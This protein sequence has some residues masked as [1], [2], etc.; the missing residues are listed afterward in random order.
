MGAGAWLASRL[1]AYADSALPPL[2]VKEIRIDAGASASFTALHVSD[3]HLTLVNGDDAGDK[4]KVKL[5]NGRIRTFPNAEHYLAKAIAT[6]H[7]NHDLLLHTGD[8]IDFVSCGNLARAGQTFAADDWYVSS[9]N[10]EF[11]KYVGEAVEDAAY[12]ADS[13]ARVQTVFPN[14]LTFASRV[15]K[16]VNFVAI[17][18]VYYNVTE[19]Q[20][21]L[22]K[23]EVA[24]GLPII[25][26]CHV[27][28]YLPRLCAKQLARNSSANVTG[29]PLEIT[30]RYSA[31]R[32]AQQR[33]DQPTADFIAW[34]KEQ[35]LLKGI[36]CGHLHKYHEERFSPTAMQYVC[37]GGF[38]GQVQRI[39]FTTNRTS[40][41]KT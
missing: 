34:L 41:G 12:K 17:D 7:A 15:V 33:T 20:H 5:A 22:F 13:Y 18:N 30:S 10:H 35:P 6:A 39:T 4:R 36:L 3:S 38:L 21:A 28:F 2:S 27:P 26:M 19:A 29:A 8:L 25:L 16:G 9:G 40:K 14:D 11:S 24:K 32:E 23:K 31:Y 37:S 1:G